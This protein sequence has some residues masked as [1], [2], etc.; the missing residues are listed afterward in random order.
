[1][2]DIQKKLILLILNLC[3]K[4]QTFSIIVIKITNNSIRS[5]V[6]KRSI[7][8][9]MEKYRIS[10]E[11][12]VKKNLFGFVCF[13]MLYEESTDVNNMVDHDSSV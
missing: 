6:F 9:T 13:R 1:M 3:K 2:G 10:T 5:S 8:K 4:K 7:K 11:T 12:V